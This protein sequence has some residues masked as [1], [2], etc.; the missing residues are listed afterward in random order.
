MRIPPLLAL[1]VAGLPAACASP[2]PRRGWADGGDPERSGSVGWI[3]GKAVTYG[4]V[5][6]YIHQREPDV[7]TRNMI[8]YIVERVTLEE[9]RPLGVTVP[10]TILA[11]ETNRRMQAWDRRVRA[12]SKAQTGQEIEPSLWL[13]RVAEMSLA[14]FRDL[15]A[16]AARVELMQDRLLRYEALVAPSVEVSMIVAEDK[17]LGERLKRE[18]E[19]GADLAE[20]ARKHSRHPSSKE[21]GRVP[22]PLL[23]ADVLEKRIRDA[24][25]A[26]KAGDIIGPFAAG[27]KGMVQIYR[28]EAARP[29]RKIRYS[30]AEPEIARGLEQRPVV[31]GEYERWRRR[32]LMRH[33]FRAEPTPG[34]TMGGPRDTAKRS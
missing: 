8:R 11:R 12:A 32:I 6:R 22:F 16:E 24:L 25:F 4:E 31:M 9:A 26:A 20:L 30:E 21:G 7:F 29:A 10:R 18:L 14:D 28:V 33:G 2:A 1:L 17:A 23:Q 19:G 13:Q 5:G 3:G 15:M 34:A 27:R